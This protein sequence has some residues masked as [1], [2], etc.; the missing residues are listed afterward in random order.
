M[1]LLSTGL[2]PFLQPPDA[3]Q[4]ALGID[5]AQLLA[6]SASQAKTPIYQNATNL[7]HQQVRRNTLQP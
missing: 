1:H 6:L 2:G 7:C 5:Y 4:A 3:I